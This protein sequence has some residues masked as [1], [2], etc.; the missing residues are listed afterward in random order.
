M[1]TLFLN[2]FVVCA[3]TTFGTVSFKSTGPK[4]WSKRTKTIRKTGHKAYPVIMS[5]LRRF[6][7]KHSNEQQHA[8]AE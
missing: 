7:A 8:S 3:F 6:Y 1:G 5:I 2:E 4:I